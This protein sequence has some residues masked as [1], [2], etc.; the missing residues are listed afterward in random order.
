MKISFK[1]AFLTFAIVWLICPPTY[2]KDKKHI[3]IDGSSTVYPI[4]EAVAEEF[5]IKNPD[6][7]ITVGVSGTGGGFK[8]F[9]AHETALND[10][11]RPIK[12][13]EIKKAKE[14]GIKY[15]EIPVAYDGL[16]VV[17][18]K[19]A[20]WIDTITVEQ[21]NRI[22][23]PGSKIK[24]WNQLNP[25]WPSHDIKLYGPG[26][27][28]GTFDYFTEAINGKSQLSRAD[29]LKSEDDNILVTGVAGD[30]YGLGYF[31][32][33]YYIENAQKIKALKID[34][35][36]GAVM[37]TMENIKSGVYAPLSRPLFV[38]VNE[39]AA[40]MPEVQKFIQFYLDEAKTLVKEVGYVPLPAEKY[41]ETWNKF[42]KFAGI[43][44]PSKS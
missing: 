24:T 9:L 22:W 32:Y 30:K 10:A 16:S 31:G 33:A 19:N 2:A 21:L 11:S 14:M 15:F 3:A 34:N 44:T 29:Y 23:K 13:K 4:T 20:D 12:E 36:K 27:D 7:K 18:N 35:G 40:K 17:V 26:T 8:K 37:P 39:K 28:S 25:K 38:Y 41:N 43:D 6:I 1:H 5:S 42:K